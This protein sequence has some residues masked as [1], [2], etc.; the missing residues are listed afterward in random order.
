MN[1][2]RTVPDAEEERRGDDEAA[3]FP[4]WRTLTE[5]AVAAG[6]ASVLSMLYAPSLFVAAV[7]A[8]IF[9]AALRLRREYA[10]SDRR[11]LESG[12]ARDALLEE[13]PDPLS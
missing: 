13:H 11:S 6:V 7:P 5:P 8:A 10:G 12:D 9:A 4:L 1:T 2:E 3:R